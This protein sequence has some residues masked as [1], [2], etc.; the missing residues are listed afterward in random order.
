MLPRTEIAEVSCRLFASGLRASRK[1]RPIAAR[2]LSLLTLAWLAAAPASRGQTLL[3]PPTVL[4]TFNGNDGGVPTATLLLASDGNL[5]GTTSGFTLA[6]TTT[7]TIENDGTVFRV[8]PAGDFTTLHTF[9]V[10]D[11]GIAPTGVAPR[12]GLIAGSN[13][14]VFYGTTSGTVNA[15]GTTTTTTTTSTTTFGTVFKITSDGDLT[16]LYIFSGGTDGNAPDAGLTLA[17]DGLLFG[18]TSLGGATSMGTVFAIDN[19]GTFQSLYDFTGVHDG[20]KPTGGLVEG[21]DGNL[22]G[23]T[24]AGGTIVA[25]KV[26]ITNHGTVFQVTPAGFVNTLYTFTGGTD[27][28][29]PT[30]GLAKPGNGYLYGTT[31]GGGDGYGTIFKINTAGQLTTLYTFTE[32]GDG[33]IPNSTL[34]VGSDGNLYGTTSGFAGASTT[35]ETGIDGGTIFRITPEGQFTVLFDFNQND[36]FETVGYSPMGGLVEDSAGNFYGT[37]S[38]GGTGDVGTVFKFNVHPDFFDGRVSLGDGIYYLSFPN[39]NYFGYY[40][41]LGANYI[42]HLDL[43]Y[44]YVIDANDGKAGVYLYDFATDSFFYTSPTYPFPYLYSFRFDTTLYYY[45]DP[46]NAGHYNTDGVR[47][48]YDFASGN[49]IAF[50]ASSSQ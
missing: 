35:G 13:S 4:H 45:P 5:Y 2:S 15:V 21:G 14:N 7:E 3:S 33:S 19:T 42:D 49:T 47:Y 50:P 46:V 38:A 1:P 32:N 20:A 22:Y 9:T 18:T 44:E 43:G 26:T 31:A 36:A 16:S 6:I 27:G 10:L 40:A 17:S 29:N 24:S 39:G 12:G 48:F 41:D 23:T 25:D 8:T 37:T 34:T 11:N 28:S 30:A